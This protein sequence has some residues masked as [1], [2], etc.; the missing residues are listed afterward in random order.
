MLEIIV[1]IKH[2]AS[3]IKHQAS[4][5]KH[6]A[7]LSAENRTHSDEASSHSAPYDAMLG[8]ETTHAVQ[9]LSHNALT[10]YK[11]S[12][13]IAEGRKTLSVNMRTCASEKFG[14]VSFGCPSKCVKCLSVNSEGVDKKA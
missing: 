14:G 6:Y 2:Q 9:A 5:I 10:E 7:Q 8:L 1:S 12:T 4:S 3:S 11:H 13:M